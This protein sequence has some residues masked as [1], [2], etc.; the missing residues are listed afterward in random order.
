MNLTVFFLFFCL[1]RCVQLVGMQIGHKHKHTHT[2]THKHKSV[3]ANKL[4]F[5][6]IENN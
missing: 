3:F 5:F 1:I 6:E 2:R 4:K